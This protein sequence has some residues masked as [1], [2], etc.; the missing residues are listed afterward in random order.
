LFQKHAYDRSE[1]IIEISTNEE[2]SLDEM[3]SDKDN[4]TK[5]AEVHNNI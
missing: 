2:K 3:S 4:R 5:S 1:K